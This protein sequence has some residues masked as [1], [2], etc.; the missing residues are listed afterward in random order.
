MK[1]RF[2]AVLFAL[3]APV[4]AFCSC[5]NGNNDIED[6]TV[7]SAE[8]I[9]SAETSVSDENADSNETEI[10]F[11]FDR[12]D[13]G[14]FLKKYIGRDKTAVVPL[15][16]DGQPVIGF[17]HDMFLDSYAKEVIFPEGMKELPFFVSDEITKI[18]IPS[19]LE[20]LDTSEL[21]YFL[22]LES[23]EVADGGNFIVDDGVLFTA[24]RKTIVYTFGCDAEYVVPEGVETLGE[25]SFSHHTFR[26]VSL[27]STLK[28]I[29]KC[30]FEGCDQISY[31][32][33]PSSVTEIGEG[34]FY[35][36]GLVDI[37]LNEGLESIGAKAFHHT[38]L[39]EILLPQS[40]KKVG[41]YF[42]NDNCKVKMFEPI[43]SL[44]T[45]SYYDISY[46]KKPTAEIAMRYLQPVSEYMLGRFMLDI[47][48]DGVPEAINIYDGS[49]TIETFSYRYRWEFPTWFN[50]ELYHFY[51][52]ENDCDFY[53]V[54]RLGEEN[55]GYSEFHRLE[56]LDGYVEDNQIGF[57]NNIGIDEA[58]S[59]QYGTLNGQYYLEESTDNDIHIL[60][61]MDGYELVEIID[62][63][64]LA[65]EQ[66]SEKAFE[67][68]LD[69]IERRSSKPLM[70]REEFCVENW[71]TMGEYNH[72]YKYD[73]SVSV[74]S[75]EELEKCCE[76]PNITTLFIHYDLENAD[77]LKK[78]K[79][80]K[81][82][83]FR[84][85][86]DPSG[87]ADMDG[88][89]FL[90]LPITDDLDFL[91][92]MDGVRAIEFNWTVD[93]PDDFFKC[94]KGM[95]NLQ[96]ILVNN[97][98]DMPITDAQC[99]WIKENLPELKVIYFW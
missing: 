91:S 93:E 84:S 85:I 25:Y 40:I 8:I 28:T 24:D 18:V 90:S 48:F 11:I 7:N 97:Y 47:N 88:I 19:T 72:L 31:M 99:L 95:K 77:G 83:T 34:A 64:K 15:E 22:W 49:A 30:A 98:C 38:K 12:T 74:F 61:A 51:D 70:T 13:S 17:S 5:T 79:N 9:S 87:L 10:P 33:I 4:F 44:G 94:V 39:S 59:L 96:Y 21:T 20:K 81:A 50:G 67:V 37:K 6:V 23:I 3:T 60:E 66:V 42:V 55:M 27:S 1:K 14:I 92:E 58:L 32:E 69:P 63:Y 52:K 68:T 45:S 78:Y 56:P 29:G 43:Y 71:I 80:L 35:S 16:I 26:S 82:L 36:T 73:S 62:L 76:L 46:L 54:S 86:A 53:V 89:E 2:I 57:I 65:E 41:D 75:E